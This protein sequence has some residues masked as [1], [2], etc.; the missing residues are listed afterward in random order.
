MKPMA[1]RMQH[2]RTNVKVWLALFRAR[3]RLAFMGLPEP[4]RGQGP[5]AVISCQ[6]LLTESGN[7]PICAL[8]SFLRSDTAL[9]ACHPVTGLRFL[10]L[11]KAN[12]ANLDGI[13]R[14]SLA[15][16]GG[17]SRAAK[18]ADCKSAGAAF[19]GSSP[20]SPTNRIWEV[21]KAEVGKFGNGSCNSRCAT[22]SEIES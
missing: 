5:R 6:P 22:P 9:P 8:R 17:V 18:G 1:L 3:V 11:P 13:W 20:T 2:G 4:V 15:S 19:V 12:A 16:H 10:A 21:E 14:H 7:S